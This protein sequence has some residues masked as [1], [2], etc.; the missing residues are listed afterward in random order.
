MALVNKSAARHISI[1]GV[2]AA[3]QGPVGAQTRRGP[4][5][6]GGVKFAR[7]GQQCELI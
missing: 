4:V 5:V 7:G 6:A 2:W 1:V 3:L